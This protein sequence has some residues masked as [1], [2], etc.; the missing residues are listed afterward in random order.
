M[1][2]SRSRE[3]WER[4]GLGLVSDW[5][6]N[7]SVLSRSQASGSRLQVTIFSYKA[8]SVIFLHSN[9]LNQIAHVGSACTK[10]LSYIMTISQIIFEEFQSRYLN[11]MDTRTDDIY[12]RITAPC[13]A[14][15]NKKC[16][17]AIVLVTWLLSNLPIMGLL[18]GEFI[19]Y[20]VLTVLYG[21]KLLLA[22]TRYRTNV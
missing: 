5:K 4:L 12:Y 19:L 7:V 20:A 11:V 8:S 21:T 13:I 16:Y 9:S 3:I 1:V 18:Y 14:S 2:S 15:R 17:N 6:S 10:A 22:S